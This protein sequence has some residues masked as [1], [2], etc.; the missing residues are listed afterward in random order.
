MDKETLSNYGWI[1]ICVLVLAVMIAL[2]TPFG[3]FIADGFKATFLGFGQTNNSM[4]DTMF[5]ATGTPP[6]VEYLQSKY[7]FEY[8]SSL[9]GAIADANNGTVGDNADT[10]KTD[11]AVGIYTDENGGVNVV[12]LKDY[13]ETARIQ[14]AADMT[15]NLGGHILT[16]END[17]YGIA[18]VQGDNT[19]TIDGQLSGSQMVLNGIDGG[20]V[21]IAP[22]TNTSLLKIVGMLLRVQKI[23]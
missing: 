9:R 15:I 7:Q 23:L 22:R 13:T 21:L 19:I 4:I 5:E 18:C 2:A 1:V 11:A 14:P 8:Y 12:L 17:Y 10:N 20:G 6:S 3:N 16:F